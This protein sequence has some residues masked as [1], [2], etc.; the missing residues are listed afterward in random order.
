MGDAA[1]TREIADGVVQVFLPLPM[2]PTVVNVYLVRAGRT[3]T[4]VDT[5]M[6]TDDSVRAFRGA[7]AD[8]G[9]APEAI[10]RIVGTH[11]HLDH[12]G[13]SDPYRALTH[14]EVYLHPL[15]AARA[16]AMRH[17]GATDGRAYLARHGAPE[18]PPD[19]DLPAPSTLF[20]SWYAPAPPDRLLGDE[21]ALPLGDGRTLEVVWTPGHTPGHCCLRLVPDGILFVGDHLLP[22]ITPHVGLWPN[23]PENPLG[24]FLASHEKIQRVEARL[25]CPAHGPVYEDHRRRARQLV[26]FHRVRKLG[27]LDAIRRR[28][29]TAYEVA[30]DAFA[31]DPQNRF[32]VLAATVETLAHLELLRREGRA[33]RDERNGVVVWSGR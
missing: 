8:L 23:G 31:I 1:K 6:N 4:L 10:T 22:K 5:G 2:K 28:P 30:L 16:T 27:M 7:L 18:V 17:V 33:L 13:T 25:V 32:Q 24:D 12:W 15:E 9:I 21:D 29:R 11:H 19:R 26:D 20:G 14:A 3:W